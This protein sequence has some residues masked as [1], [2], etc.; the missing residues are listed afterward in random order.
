MPLFGIL[1]WGV[2]VTGWRLPLSERKR[3]GVAAACQ[4]ISKQGGRTARPRYRSYDFEK[5]V[6]SSKHFLAIEKGKSSSPEA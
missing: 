3:D 2:G 1:I 6:A 4:F 5:I